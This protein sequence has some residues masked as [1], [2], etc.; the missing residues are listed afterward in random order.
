MTDR[1]AVSFS[2]LTPDLMADP[3]PAYERLR[4]ADPVH[5]SAGENGWVLS[6]H[7]DVAAVM[8]DR[9]F[10]V[11]ELARTV[12]HLTRTASKPCADLV[13]VL[14]AVLFLRNPPA[15]GE[16]RR[17]LVAVL[18]DKPL[19]AHVPVIEAVAA[20][21]LP[22]AGAGAPFDAV[23]AYADRV[24]PLF[25]GRL[26]GLSDDQVSAIMAIVSEVTMTFDRGR[27]LRFY[28]RVDRTV[29]AAIE[30]FAAEIAGRRRGPRHDGLSRMIALS[31]E[32]FHLSDLEI[33]SRALFLLIAGVETTSALIGAAIAAIVARPDLA[34]RLRGDPA[35][36][37]RAVEEVLRHDGP[38]Q[39]ATRFAT[40]D[41]V[42]GGQPV[43]A[44]DR[45]VLLVG[46]AHRDA[47]AYDAP[48]TFDIDRKDA[49]HLGFGAGLHH[50]LG[51]S[52]A[53]LEAQ[54]AVSALLARDPHPQPGLRPE[55]W[56]HRT[57]R[58][59][60]SYPLTLGSADLQWKSTT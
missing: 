9:T 43:R 22:K 24:P 49:A 30:I 5:W 14:E 16:G 58:R 50:C 37:E 6:R 42:I 48:A 20:S 47:A 12:D 51:A 36:V 15:H 11:V 19:S 23:T 52:L 10:E 4:A 57:L 31:D 35:A 27:S 56:P 38:V 54:I 17:F 8:A 59:L 60:K 55:F 45:I 40:R 1:A 39:Q 2:T 25:M 33:A 28:Q 7:A 44:G 34:R 29:A 26:L 21:L 32:R 18:T 46:A 53:R 41:T 3:Y 13:G